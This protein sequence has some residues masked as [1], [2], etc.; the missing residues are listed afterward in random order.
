VSKHGWWRSSTEWK[1]FHPAMQNSSSTSWSIAACCALSEQCNE[2]LPW[3]CLAMR[4]R[5][6]SA[7]CQV[8]CQQDQKAVTLVQQ[9]TQTSNTQENEG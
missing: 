2:R 4:A 6:S 3:R 9:H 7:A 8:G 5:S 1:P